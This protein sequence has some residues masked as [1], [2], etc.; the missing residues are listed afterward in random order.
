MRDRKR[1]GSGEAA[2]GVGA[3]EDLARARGGGGGVDHLDRPA[4]GANGGG[5]FANAVLRSATGRGIGDDR[6]R[7]RRFGGRDGEGC[8][9]D[10]GDVRGEEDESGAEPVTKR[11][12]QNG[13]GRGALMASGT[14][15]RV[16]RAGEERPK[17]CAS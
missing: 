9:C 8:T 5:E 7:A 15:W 2:R 13:R 10:E 12:S 16:G 6:E 1:L 14:V 17:D 3:R 11:E 4:A